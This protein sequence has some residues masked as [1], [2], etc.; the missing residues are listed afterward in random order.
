MNL[1]DGP[2]HAH[3]EPT[4]ICNLR[5]HSCINHAL[6]KAR[7]GVMSLEDYKRVLDAIPTLNDVSLIGLGEP[8]T[9]PDILQMALETRSRNIVVRTVTNGMLLQRF[10]RQLILESFDELVFSIDG[11][12]PMVL[13]S[14]RE[15]SDWE[16]FIENLSA[17]HETKKQKKL[18]TPITSN[19]VLSDKNLGEVPG[20]FELALR[21]GFSKLR[22]VFAVDTVGTDTGSTNM[23]EK[24]KDIEALKIRDEKLESELREQIES[25]SRKYGLPA[26]F[27]G[28]Q[29]Y[30]PNCWW[31][32]RGVYV[33]FDGFVTPCCL[34]MDPEVIHFGNLFNESFLSI[35]NGERYRGFRQTFQEKQ[36]PAICRSCP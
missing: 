8:F 18:K 5:C 35:W 10:D 1:A 9:H 7:R 22:F 2:V 33:T 15:G 24:R 31:P 11:A 16:L 23:Q 36:V 34:R 28:S 30:A 21:F 25:L 20:I 19:T 3:I 14:L 4:T 26:S 13:E 32:I 17:L 6:P 27:S 12:S 29:P